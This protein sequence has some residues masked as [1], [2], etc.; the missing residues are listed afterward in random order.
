MRASRNVI[1]H[2]ITVLTIRTEKQHAS[3]F[4]NNRKCYYMAR[5]LD[6]RQCCRK[7]TQCLSAEL[8]RNNIQ[9]SSRND[10]SSQSGNISDL[11]TMMNKAYKLGET[12]GVQEVLKSN[13]ILTTL[14]A[15]YDAADKVASELI[16]AAILAAGNER[17]VMAAIIN[18]ILAS[19]C[20]G[21]DHDDGNENVDNNENSSSPPSSSFVQHPQI[22]LEILHLMDCMY[23]K[24]PSSIIMPDIVSL[25]LVYYALSPP[26][27]S[28]RQ[29]SQQLHDNHYVPQSNEILD[30]ARRMAKKAAGSQR[31]KALASERRKGRLNNNEKNEID[32]TQTEASLQSLFGQDI[33]VLYET[34]D[35]IAVSKPSGMVCYHTK[36]TGSNS[37]RTDISL[38]DALLE[39]NVSLSTVNPMARGIVHR[40]DRG[41]SGSI[42]IAKTDEIHLIL[43]ASFFL[44]QSEKKYL[45]L[46][47]GKSAIPTHSQ[48]L[49]EGSSGVINGP[50]DGRPASSTY[51]VVKVF[52]NE[53]SPDALLLE[54]STLTGRKHQVRVHCASLGHPIFRDPLYDATSSSATSL[55]SNNSKKTA[56]GQKKQRAGSSKAVSTGTDDLPLP[57]AIADVI[58]DTTSNPQY[59]ERFFLHAAFLSINELGVAVNAPLPKWWAD[60]MEKLN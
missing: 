22:A 23:S 32:M 60:T 13:R 43:V 38:V 35:I 48:L 21:D 8:I 16:N 5:H 3:S 37:K 36:S 27:P 40:L 25:S 51:R 1:V 55:E 41:T 46:V 7:S 33:H 50:V 17:G 59:V 56:I 49:L 28:Q 2:A 20:H 30:R 11:S 45:A 9:S 58:V 44:R 15:K 54:V 42:I 31:R 24:D 29:S 47:R 12:D 19:C 52:G 34:A 57:K 14:L 10:E 6:R 4:L 18:S 26:S 39:C 53:L